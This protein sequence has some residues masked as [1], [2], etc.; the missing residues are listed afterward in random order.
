MFSISLRW[1]VLGAS[2]ILVAASAAAQSRPTTREQMWF[3]PTAEDWKKPCLIKWQRSWA[4]AQAV[5]KETGKPILVCI[6]MDGEIA[7]EHYAGVRYRQPEIA[8]LYEPYVCVIASVYRHSPRDYD[9]QGARIPCPRFGTVTCGEHIAIEPLLHEKFMDG[10]RIAPRHIGVELDGREMYDVYYAWDTDTI[11]DN[12]RAGIANRPPPKPVVRGDRSLVEKVGSR[13]SQ[14]RAAIEAMYRDGDKE[15]RKALVEAALAN[16]A[17]APVDL[18]R[19]AIF[20]LDPETGASARRALAQSGEDGAVDLIGEALRVPMQPAEKD[21]LV[22]ALTRLGETSPRARTLSVVHQGL[23]LRSEAVDADGWA[24]A[25]ESGDSVAR[26]ISARSLSPLAREAAAASARSLVEARVAN[27]AKV[28][29]SSDAAALLDV[30]DA[31]LAAAIEAGPTQESSKA[32]LEDA[33]SAAL[34]A[35][36]LGAY[37]WAPN[38]TIAVAAYYLGNLDEAY[39]RAEAATKDTAVDPDGWNAMVVLGLFGEMRQKAIVKAIEEKKDWPKQWLTDVH[40]AY[41]VL[42]RHPNGDDNHVAVHYD[43]LKWLGALGQA[44]RVLDEGLARFPESEYLHGRLRIKLLQEKG[45]EGLEPAY[46]TMLAA[47]DAPPSLPWFAGL[48]S[49]RAAEHHRRTRHPDEALASYGRA[50]GHFEKSIQT[51]PDWRDGADRAIALAFAARARLAYER[52]EDEKAL[53]QLLASIER[54]PDAYATQDG[55]NISPADTG[56]ILLARL[57]ETQRDDL[58]AK[59][60]AALAKLDP[61]LLRLPAYERD[62]ASSGPAASRPA[63]R[64]RGQNR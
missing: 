54:R 37:G 63:S 51:M 57:K 34:K 16:G 10:K 47:K 4:D 59:L 30:A 64:R 49:V 41:S 43:F 6:N 38:A 19:L 61:E 60:E 55:L 9:E 46:E 40:A 53:V 32:L 35:E 33:R 27:R 18:L 39:A 25:L 26:A 28:L 14:D 7:S 20:G 3:A 50:V 12:L 62:G 45:V 5:S 23:S 13:D 36:K 58:A 48:A 15:S 42:G 21:A 56:R 17:A 29:E 22:G 2:L 44:A 31:C 24:K 8:A 52:R 11:F 1:S